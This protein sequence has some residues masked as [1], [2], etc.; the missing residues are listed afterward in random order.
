MKRY[1]FTL[2]VSLLQVIKHI[3]SPSD[4]AFSLFSRQALETLQMKNQLHLPEVVPGFNESPA[5]VLYATIDFSKCYHRDD[6]KGYSYGVWLLKHCQSCTKQNHLECVKN[7]FFYFPELHLK[8]RLTHNAFIIWDSNWAH[9]TSKGNPT[10]ST[11]CKATQY[12]TCMTNKRA[13]IHAREVLMEGVKNGN[14]K[15]ISQ[16]VSEEYKWNF[17][18]K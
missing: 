15:Y 4:K 6:D 17:I 8:I 12:A 11:T 3:F 2:L 16:L 14:E 5:S 7:W 10:D 9:A 1:Y 18:Y 13:V